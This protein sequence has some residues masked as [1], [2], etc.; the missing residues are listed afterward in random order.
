MKDGGRSDCARHPIRKLLRHRRQIK[1]LTLFTLF[2]LVPR[3][4]LWEKGSRPPTMPPWVEGARGAN[5]PSGCTDPWGHAA[6]RPSPS[7]FGARPRLPP[8]PSGPKAGL[9]WGSAHSRSAP[10]RS[11]P[12]HPPPSRPLENVG[13]F[14]PGAR[15]AHVAPL[16]LGSQRAPCRPRWAKG[17]SGPQIVR[18]G[19][20]GSSASATSLFFCPPAL[21]ADN[22]TQ[23]KLSKLLRQAGRSIR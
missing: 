8:L 20:L 15:W 9:G 1:Q 4:P 7:A 16:G 2:P 22:W 6:N 5:R 13:G 23:G 3:G 10:P 11:G 14:L 18:C 19:C 17:P 12:H 21:P